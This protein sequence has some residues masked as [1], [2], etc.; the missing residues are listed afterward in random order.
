M[1]DEN[2]DVPEPAAAEAEHTAVLSSLKDLWVELKT[3]GGNEDAGQKLVME[4]YS[5][6]TRA[7]TGGPLRAKPA[8][9]TTPYGANARPAITANFGTDNNRPETGTALATVAAS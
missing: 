3:H 5:T 2:S 7:K 9:R 4:W 8:P 1:L 6:M